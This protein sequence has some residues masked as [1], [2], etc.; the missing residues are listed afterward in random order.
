MIIIFWEYG[1]LYNIINCIFILFSCKKIIYRLYILLIF[2]NIKVFVV[3]GLILRII[4][5]T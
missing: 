5:N 4:E 3:I 2:I 1:I